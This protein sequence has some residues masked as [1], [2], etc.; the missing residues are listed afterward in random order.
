MLQ[1]QLNSTKCDLISGRARGKRSDKEDEEEEEEMRVGERVGEGEE[2][3]KR[4][5]SNRRRCDAGDAIDCVMLLERKDVERGKEAE[6]KSDE[7][8]G[9]TY[10]INVKSR[11]RCDVIT[12]VVD[13]LS[14][15]AST[16]V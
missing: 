11:R 3:E 10:S 2:E 12:S 16:D 9:L 1:N 5:N 6:D 15:T 14:S 4:S 13:N 7:E 8:R